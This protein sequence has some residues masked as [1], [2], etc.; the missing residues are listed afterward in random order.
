MCFLLDGLDEASSSSRLFDFLLKK[1]IPGKPLRYPKLSVIMTSRPNVR[2]SKGLEAFIK[3][4]VVI[5]GF[6]KEDLSL[7]LDQTLGDDSDERRKLA[8]MFVINPRI[9]GFCSLPIKLCGYHVILDP[10]CQR[11]GTHNTNRTEGGSP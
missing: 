11:Q 4:R 6:K 1:L 9:E 10:L 8:E 2:V 7:Y 3:S 5:T